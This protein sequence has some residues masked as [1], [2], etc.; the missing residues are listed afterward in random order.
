MQ[1]KKL[2]K[3]GQLKKLDLDK[4]V[5]GDRKENTVV[6]TQ[7]MDMN[8]RDRKKRKEC[9]TPAM[10]K[11]KSVD[12]KYKKTDITTTTTI[13]TWNIT[14]IQGKEI[15]LTE[16]IKFCNLQLLGISETRKT[17]KGQVCV[18]DK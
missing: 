8:V 16:V 3:S 17:D 5:E 1:T 13:G 10:A 11:E 18:T 6:Q 14:A 9:M 4:K 12:A 15:E 2:K 7:A